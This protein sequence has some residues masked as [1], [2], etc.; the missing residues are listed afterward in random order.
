MTDPQRLK[1]QRQYDA[2]GKAEAV[3]FQT[4]F[5]LRHYL[6]LKSLGGHFVRREIG[7]RWF[8]V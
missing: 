1:P 3:P 6:N 2:Y 8:A 7:G 4:R 5:E